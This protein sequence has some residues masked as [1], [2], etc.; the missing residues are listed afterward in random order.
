MKKTSKTQVKKELQTI[1]RK[2][3]WAR[4]GS[5]LDSLVKEH[6]KTALQLQDGEM[7]NEN[8][9]MRNTYTARKKKFCQEYERY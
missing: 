9:K 1:R 8:N 4:D 6:K 3:S 5:E 7:I 2:M